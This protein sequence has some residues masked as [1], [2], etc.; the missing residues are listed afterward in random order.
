VGPEIGHQLKDARDHDDG[1]RVAA[2][3][4]HGKADGFGTVDE[5]PAT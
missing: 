5:E 4:L 1:P 3:L 2:I